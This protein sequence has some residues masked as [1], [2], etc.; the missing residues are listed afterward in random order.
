[1][2]DAREISEELGNTTVKVKSYS[3]PQWSSARK[4]ENTVNESEQRRPLLL[5]QEVMAMGKDQA[6][7]FYEGLPPIRCQK[8]RYF[9]DRRFTVRLHPPP[10]VD[11]LDPPPES[12]P[13]ASSV[14]V[15]GEAGAEGQIMEAST[16]RE[17]TLEDIDRLEELQLADFAA[18]IAQI[19]VP[20]EGRLTEEQLGGLAIEF[21]NL[22]K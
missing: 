22:W 14:P 15:A 9:K 19:V 13:P 12:G 21:M 16:V 8:I 18:P 3:R 6:L 11:P 20:Q 7:V 2:A 5:P 1:M 10:E 17:A 4:R